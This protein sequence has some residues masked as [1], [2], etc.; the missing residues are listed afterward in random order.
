MDV[1]GK[2]VLITG[3]AG[4]IGKSLARRFLAGGAVVVL[5]D[6]NAQSLASAKKD[7]TSAGGKVFTHALDIS[8]RAAV[9]EAAKRV[10]SEAGDVDILDNN[11]G[12]VA[13]GDFLEVSEDSLSRTISVNVNAVIWCTRAFLPS[14]VAKGSGHIIMMASAAGLLG[15]PGMAAYSASKHA[16]IGLAESLRLELRKK[17]AHGV[18]MT[19][20]CPS[21]VNT[22]MFDGVK[23]PL[24]TP[25]L[26]PEELTGKIYEAVLAGRLYVREPFM[27]K[28]IPALKGLPSTAAIDWLGRILG[29]DASM[30]HWTGRR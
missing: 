15:V 14:M 16:V 24:L 17:G 27:V 21:F 18:K 3:G 1:R 20:V 22:G 26:E 8:D 29:M 5:W 4:G 30:D 11:A 9:D 10:R 19:I 23:P 6:I 12:I 13:G 25:W 7:L 2:V 28:L